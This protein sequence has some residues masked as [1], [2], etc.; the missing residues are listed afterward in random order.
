M[1]N[2][3]SASF[4]SQSLTQALAAANRILPTSRLLQVPR[5]GQAGCPATS[6]AMQ[7]SPSLKRFTQGVNLSGRVAVRANVDR[8]TF[9]V[10]GLERPL[11]RLAGAA[12][13][14]LCRVNHTCPGLFRTLPF[15]PA[16]S[17]TPVIRPSV[18]CAPGGLRV[19]WASRQPPVLMSAPSCNLH[20]SGGR[21]PAVARPW[22]SPRHA[23]P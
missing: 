3:R 16:R 11:H 9:K 19:V 7:Q 15:P 22:P 2:L 5:W 21:H 20:G 4:A 18:R 10:V 1:R 12:R 17:T 8:T 14:S 6:M 23:R 13:S